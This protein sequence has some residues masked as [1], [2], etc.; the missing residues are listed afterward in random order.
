MNADDLSEG[1]E[2]QRLLPIVMIKTPPGEFDQNPLK[3]SFDC[4][5]EASFLVDL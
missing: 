1:L 2:N 5:N 3:I 4:H